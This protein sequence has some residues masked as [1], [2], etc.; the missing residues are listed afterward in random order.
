MANKSEWI[1]VLYSTLKLWYTVRELIQNRDLP[2]KTNR[3]TKSIPL[4]RRLFMEYCYFPDVVQVVPFE[5]YTVDVYFDDGKIV[6]YD[7]MPSL[8]DG[9]FRKLKDLQIFMNS[10]TI[11]NGTLAWDI[12][13]DRNE[14][15]CIDI[16]PETLHAL[17]DASERI[18]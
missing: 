17:P 9:I 18:V 15:E 5:D 10:C 14:Y 11:L 6:R 13:G 16:D 4:F 1:L 8:E 2:K 12:S 3:L 7:A